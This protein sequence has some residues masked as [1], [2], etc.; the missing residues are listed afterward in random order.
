[1]NPC[2]RTMSAI[3]AAGGIAEVVERWIPGR[4]IRVDLFGIGDVLAIRPGERP[5]LIQA[6][7]G[8]HVAAR[9]AKAKAEPRLRAW[10][11]TGS[12]FEVHGW[13]KVDGRWHC[14]I[15]PLVLDDVD[16]L[17]SIPP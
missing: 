8:S 16:G 3:R 10:L 7:T 6:T 1:M 13:G 15:V 5:L 12:T 9:I 4:N 14:R 2:A 17:A 11:R